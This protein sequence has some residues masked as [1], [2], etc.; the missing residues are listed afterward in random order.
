M[1]RRGLIGEFVSIY[2][3]EKQSSVYIATDGGRVCRPL[4]IVENGEWVDSWSYE[5]FWRYVFIYKCVCICRRSEA[6]Q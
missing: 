6:D 2:L 3:N 4:L 1:R 5:D